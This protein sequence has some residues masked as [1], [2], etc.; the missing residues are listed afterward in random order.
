M[1][2]DTALSLLDV[3]TTGDAERRTAAL[4]LAAEVLQH[5]VPR[6]KVKRSAFPHE[7]TDMARFILDG[8]DIFNETEQS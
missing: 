8:S 2:T 4:F 3:D 5:Q 6:P 7:L 1:D